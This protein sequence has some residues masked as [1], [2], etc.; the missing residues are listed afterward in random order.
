[1]GA[2]PLPVAL[3]GGLL[4]PDR[5]LHESVA[6]GL[7]SRAGAMV[8]RGAIDPCRGAIYLVNEGPPKPGHAG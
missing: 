6:A 7:E 3:A 4:A 1:A 5:P 8:A 2:G